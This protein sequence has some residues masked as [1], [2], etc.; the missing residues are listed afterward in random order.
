VNRASHRPYSAYNATRSGAPVFGKSRPVLTT[1]ND[2]LPFGAWLIIATLTG[3]ALMGVA[4]LSL[5]SI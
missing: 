4:S 2:G 1:R 5:G 3:F